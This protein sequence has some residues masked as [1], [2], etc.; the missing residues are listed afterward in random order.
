MIEG[1]REIIRAGYKAGRP[2]ADIARDCDSTRGSVK[3]IAH[4]MGIRHKKYVSERVPADLVS[5]YLN[6]VKRKSL[7]V[8]FAYQVLGIAP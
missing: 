5:D 2:V 8:K 6:I 4:K 3:V 1:G 7:G